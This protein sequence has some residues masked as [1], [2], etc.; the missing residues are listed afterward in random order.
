MSQ[1]S[2]KLNKEIKKNVS[3]NYLL[4][5]PKDYALE[6]DKRWPLIMFLHGMG[7]RGED[8]ELIKINGITK[9]IEEG[10]EFP[11]IIVSPHC[12][13][14]SFWT[15]ENEPLMTLLD[16]ITEKYR[17][18]ESRIYLTGLS[19][20][21]YGTW[22]LSIQYPERFAAIAP[23]CGAGIDGMVYRIKDI[24]VWAFH[25]EKDNVVPIRETEIMVNELKA[26]GGS[27][28]FTV[29]PEAGHDSWTE[30]YKNPELYKRFLEHRKEN[31]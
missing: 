15:L 30:T 5:L 9:E 22:N 13:G 8:I 19:M 1:Q 24:P 12:P 10:K 26:V 6:A 11:F 17:V 3:L 28:R 29:Y 23:V 2:F 4:Y 18:D 14:D 7:E 31:K 27:A 20:G 16:E 21:G 25:G